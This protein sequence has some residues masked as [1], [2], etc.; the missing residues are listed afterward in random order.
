[1]DYISTRGAAPVL[2]FTDA[3]ITGLAEDGGLYLPK[4]YP[5]F[6][7]AEIAA[8]AG[9]PYAAVAEARHLAIRLRKRSNAQCC[10]T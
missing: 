9:Q 4:S 10:A 8:F 2:S 7:T 3:L 1:M 5:E 6:S